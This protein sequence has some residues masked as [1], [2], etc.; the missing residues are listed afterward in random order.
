MNGG[1]EQNVTAA[2]NWHLFSNVKLQLNYVYADI[3]DTGDQLSNASGH[4][5]AFQSRAQIEF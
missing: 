4:I 5:H 2:L 1:E 3:D